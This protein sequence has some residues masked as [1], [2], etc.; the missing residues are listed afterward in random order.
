M[1]QGKSI[2]LAVDFKVYFAESMF[3]LVAEGRKEGS[4][5]FVTE[6][7]EDY[8]SIFYHV[9]LTLLGR[10]DKADRTVS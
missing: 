5:E 10:Y 7:K 2:K 6:M 9:N 1:L 3:Y 8:L 4:F